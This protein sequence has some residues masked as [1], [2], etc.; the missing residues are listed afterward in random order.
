MKRL[1]KTQY[2]KVSWEWFDNED[3]KNPLLRKAFYIVMVHNSTIIR[4]NKA[5]IQC[6]IKPNEKL[7]DIG[8]FLN[9]YEVSYPRTKAPSE[10]RGYLP[11]VVANKRMDHAKRAKNFSFTMDNCYESMDELVKLLSKYYVV[12]SQYA[13]RQPL[14]EAKEGTYP[15]ENVLIDVMRYDMDLY[16]LVTPIDRPGEITTLHFHIKL[17]T[18][19][20]YPNEDAYQKVRARIFDQIEAR[21]FAFCD[22]VASTYYGDQNPFDDSN[23]SGRNAYIRLFNHV[24]ESGE[25]DVDSAIRK[26]A[27]KRETLDYLSKCTIFEA[28][29]SIVAGDNHYYQKGNKAFDF[30]KI[31]A[32]IAGCHCIKDSK[33]YILQNKRVLERHIIREGLKKLKFEKYG[34]P[35]NMLKIGDITIARNGDIWMILEFK[36]RLRKLMSDSTVEG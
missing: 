1:E 3:T 35:V 16:P 30:I 18:P 20:Y 4:D 15:H 17:E 9:R 6:R 33:D 34:I 10:I 23:Q 31:G 11:E 14:S 5:I 7:V 12:H 13:I 21:Y 24:F 26:I 29:T 22:Y 32:S 28:E 27:A 8:S 2:S 19:R 36:D 25:G